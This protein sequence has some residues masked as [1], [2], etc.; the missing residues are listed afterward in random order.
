[1]SKRKEIRK[2]GREK[3]ERK[4]SNF[5]GETKSDKGSD[6]VLDG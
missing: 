3:K 1:L 5:N 4:I 2:R 6:M